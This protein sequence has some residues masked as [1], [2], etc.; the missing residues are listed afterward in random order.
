MKNKGKCEMEFQ[1]DQE[2]IKKFQLPKDKFAFQTHQELDEF[3]YSLMLKCPTF[4]LDYENER[5]LLKSFDRYVK[6]FLQKQ[7]FNTI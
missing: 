6:K 2:F 4:K 5:T 7:I 1:P 3:M